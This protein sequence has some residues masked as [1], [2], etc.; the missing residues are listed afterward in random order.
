MPILPKNYLMSENANRNQVKYN[1]L[2][3]IRETAINFKRCNT[4]DTALCTLCLTFALLIYTFFFCVQNNEK[5]VLYPEVN[6][7]KKVK[8]GGSTKI[9]P[10]EAQVW[11]VQKVNE[12]YL[13]D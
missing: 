9:W 2:D 4:I 7:S 13:G 8:K 3:I 1:N 5:I 10:P 12:Q 6:C 11:T